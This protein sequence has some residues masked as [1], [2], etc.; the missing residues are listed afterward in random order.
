ML[1][2]RQDLVGRLLFCALQNVKPEKLFSRQRAVEQLLGI[3]EGTTMEK[4]GSF[5][6]WDGQSIPF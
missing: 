3:I 5:I 2:P 4:S 6:A 1:L